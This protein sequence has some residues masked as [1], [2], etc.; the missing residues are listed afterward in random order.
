MSDGNNAADKSL[1]S[2]SFPVRLMAGRQT[3]D[4][5]TVVRVHHRELFIGGL[6]VNP[7]REVWRASININM[8]S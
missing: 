6:T 1:K 4:L 2:K 5:P 7:E 3:L 8:G